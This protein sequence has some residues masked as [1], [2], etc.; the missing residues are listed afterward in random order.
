MSDEQHKLTDKEMEDFQ[1]IT[2]D[3]LAN[4]CAVA[5]KHNINRD[6]ML[7]YFSGMLT[8]FAEVASIQNYEINHSYG[9][10]TIYDV[11]KIVEQ[12]E[13]ERELSYADFDKYVEEVSPCLDAEY[14]DSFQRG[15]ERAIKIIKRQV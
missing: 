8:A 7:K 10:N 11:D 12:L 3:T 5:D 13:E 15:L 4:I 14:D 1:S 2:A 9:H 6:S